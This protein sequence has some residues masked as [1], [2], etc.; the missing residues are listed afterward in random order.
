[1]RLG[2]VLVA[3]AA[4]SGPRPDVYITIDR[5]AV[6]TVRELGGTLIASEGDIALVDIDAA[7]LDALGAQL[8]ARFRRC[9]GFMIHDSLDDAPAALHPHAA[10]TDVDYTL[11]R[12]DAVRAILPQLDRERILATIRELSAMPNRYYKSESGAA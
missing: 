8:H 3:A 5:D 11:D 6:D 12:G 9:G 7:R 1:M 2:L 10:T 4:C